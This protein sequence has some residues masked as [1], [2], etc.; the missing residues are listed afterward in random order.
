[1]R[2]SA[3]TAKPSGKVLLTCPRRECP[4]KPGVASDHITH[5]QRVERIAEV[6]EGPAD[7]NDLDCVLKQLDSM[8]ERMKHLEVETQLLQCNLTVCFTHPDKMAALSRGREEP[9]WPGTAQDPRWEAV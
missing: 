2:V 9:A 3:I 1:M 5:M 8:L 4:S 6:G 7:P